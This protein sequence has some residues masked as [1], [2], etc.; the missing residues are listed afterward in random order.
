ME[1][2]RLNPRFAEAYRN[3]ARLLRARGKVREAEK[4]EDMAARSGDTPR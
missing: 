2:I 3:L 4:A 1:A